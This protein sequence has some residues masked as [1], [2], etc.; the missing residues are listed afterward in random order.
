MATATVVKSGNSRAICLPKSLGATD[1]VIGSKVEID[2]L[3]DSTLTVKLKPP[4]E[5][6]LRA[7]DGLI[8]FAESVP[9][10]PWNDDSREADRK[11]LG[12]R[13]V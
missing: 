11:L 13:L 3:D 7:L 5:G 8:E 4:R 2:M 9:S 10:I 12:D 1:F 6:R